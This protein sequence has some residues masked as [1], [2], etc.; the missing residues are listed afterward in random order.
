MNR[1]ETLKTLALAIGIGVTVFVAATPV[2][3]WGL[4]VDS[5]ERMM[6][7]ILSMKRPHS[8]MSYCED[9]FDLFR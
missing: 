8:D 5:C 6:C 2:C 9:W 3:I 7:E 4:G 1:K